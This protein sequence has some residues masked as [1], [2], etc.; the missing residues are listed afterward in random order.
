VAAELEELAA[1]LANSTYL[2]RCPACGQYWGGHGYTPHFRWEL[3]PSEAA[4]FFLHAF[5]PGINRH[6]TTE[7]QQILARKAQ[8]A[9]EGNPGAAHPLAP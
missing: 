6:E 8:D 1:D 3:T 4:K 5:V 2:C 7:A 9:G